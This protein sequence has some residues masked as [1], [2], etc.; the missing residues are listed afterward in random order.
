M[1]V[2]LVTSVVF[3]AVF[4]YMLLKLAKMNEDRLDDCI[5]FIG[6]ITRLEKELADH[7]GENP[8]A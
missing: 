6:E 8:S 5:Y 7:S 2:W 4:I 1:T 3:N